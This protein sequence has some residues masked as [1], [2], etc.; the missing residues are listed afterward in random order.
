MATS[1]SATEADNAATFRVG[2]QEYN[3]QRPASY[4]IFV[5]PHA[6]ERLQIWSNFQATFHHYSSARRCLLTALSEDFDGYR[7]VSSRPDHTGEKWTIIDPSNGD[8]IG[9]AYC[10][11][12]AAR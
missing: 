1:V 3:N 5:E 2:T 12:G 6:P 8:V 4:S 10:L 11:L 7:T 9:W